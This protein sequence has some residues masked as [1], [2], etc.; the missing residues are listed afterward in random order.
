M[1]ISSAR[2]SDWVEHRRTRALELELSRKWFVSDR[3]RGLPHI[4]AKVAS[5]EADVYE[6]LTVLKRWVPR[7]ADTATLRVQQKFPAKSS[8]RLTALARRCLVPTC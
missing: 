5:I 4:V 6:A 8:A 1:P 3:A 7:D 2:G